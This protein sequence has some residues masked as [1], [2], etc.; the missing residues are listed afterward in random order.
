M[1]KVEIYTKSWCPYSNR[2][3][4]FL[5]RNCKPIVGPP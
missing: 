5:D 2:A 1:A 3:K 4:Y